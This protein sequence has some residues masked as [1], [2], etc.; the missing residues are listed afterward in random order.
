M[1]H[2]WLLLV[3]VTT[4]AHADDYVPAP[5]RSFAIGLGGYGNYV[6]GVSET[7]YGPSLELAI[8]VGRWQPFL[9]GSIATASVG[10]WTMSALD[11]HIDGWMGRAGAGVRWLAR[12]FRPDPDGTIELYLDAFA[13]VERFWWHDGTRITRPDVGVG[14]GTQVRM[15][16][17]HNL[18]TR[19][20]VRLVF[21]PTDRDSALI[22]C[23]GTC[24]P[25]TTN[26]SS[27]GFMGGIQ[28]GW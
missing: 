13:G 17:F 8:G 7:G 14:F 22:S 24:T 10:S 3:L 6:N 28:L 12:Q 11:S 27:V 2:V 1:R 21:T 16:E 15:L 18:T 4:T 5:S 9:E 26:D 23:R 20:D 19:I 25:M